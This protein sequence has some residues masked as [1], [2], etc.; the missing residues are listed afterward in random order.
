MTLFGYES[1]R[2][3]TCILLSVDHYFLRKKAR[4]AITCILLIFTF[5]E[6]SQESH[7][8]HLAQ[9]RWSLLVEKRLGETIHAFR[10]VWIIPLFGYKART[11]ITYISLG[12]DHDFIWI[13]G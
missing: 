11:A 2:G 5:Y 12:V 6:K 1:R 7:Y 3:I 13:L 9:C 10:S 4:E 8:V